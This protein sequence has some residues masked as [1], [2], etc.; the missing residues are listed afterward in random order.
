MNKR[1]LNGVVKGLI[2]STPLTTYDPVVVRAGRPF[3]VLG[4]NSHFPSVTL[5]SGSVFEI[6]GNPDYPGT[7][8]RLEIGELIIM[9]NGPAAV[10][11]LIDENS[12]EID[13]DHGMDGLPGPNG[14]RNP[15]NLTVV[16]ARDGLDGDN[17]EAGE[18]IASRGTLYLSISNIKV[19]PE[20]NLTKAILN[21][22]GKGIR[23]G[24]GGN[25]GRGGNGGNGVPS[26]NGRHKCR[27]FPESGCY[28]KRANSVGGK[29]ANGGSGGSPGNGGNGGN[30]ADI[31][32]HGPASIFKMLKSVTELDG[33]KAGTG[34]TGGGAGDF[35]RGAK[36]A[37]G[38]T[39]GKCQT[40][41][42]QPDGKPGESRV[43][44]IGERGKAGQTGS[45]ELID[46]LPSYPDLMKRMLK[47]LLG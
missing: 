1:E 7:P 19:V 45:I 39:R 33:G 34:G 6:V 13:G 40:Y 38:G 32:F 26:I 4:A 29:G 22:D 17:G 15:R 30:G 23:G 10:I 24:N 14:G 41:K 16:E 28:C 46:S 9:P 2:A 5:H 18:T 47:S 44:L 27:R 3:R 25:G 42:A 11:K 43:L 31:Y 21:F 20:V 8:I 36:A 12:F 35:G 37:V